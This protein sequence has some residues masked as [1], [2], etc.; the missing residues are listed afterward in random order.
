MK[1]EQNT[2]TKLKPRFEIVCDKTILDGGKRR[3]DH[4]NEDIM[5]ST[6]CKFTL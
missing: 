6:K 1:V 3:E 5:S 4:V 2:R